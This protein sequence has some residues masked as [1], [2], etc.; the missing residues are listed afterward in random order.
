MLLSIEKGKFYKIE[1]S[2]IRESDQDTVFFYI[3]IENMNYILN[4]IFDCKI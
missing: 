2:Q 3:K 1:F 4:I